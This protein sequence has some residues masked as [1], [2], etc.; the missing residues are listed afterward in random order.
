MTPGSVMDVVG[1]DVSPER[2]GAAGSRHTAPTRLHRTPS[3]PG[4]GVGRGE[5]SQQ[6]LLLSLSHTAR[7]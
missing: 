7:R 4:T 1:M 6:Q 3:K 2:A 5:G